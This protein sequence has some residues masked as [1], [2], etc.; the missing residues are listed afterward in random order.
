MLLRIA[1]MGSSSCRHKKCIN[2]NKICGG[3]TTDSKEQML[4]KSYAANASKL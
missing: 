1:L 3:T 2:Y 4:I